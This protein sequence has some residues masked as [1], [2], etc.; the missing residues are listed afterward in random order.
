LSATFHNRILV[1]GAGSVAQCAIPLLLEHLVEAKQM[2]I[3]D[4]R[5][6]RSRVQSAIDQG[7]MYVQEEL[8]PSNLNEFLSRFLSEGDFLL[9][10][11]WNID[12]NAIIEWAHD[13][14]VIYV[15]TSLEEWE[16][17][18]GGPE[19]SVQSRTLYVRHMRIREMKAKWTQTGPTA[20]VEHGANPGFVSHLV[21]RGLVDIATREIKDGLAADGV[22]KALNEGNFPVLA[23]TLG[24]KVIH[25]AERDT[26]VA[27]KPKLLG[28]FVNTWS[29]EGFYEE[30]IA[31]A[32]LGWG[33]H[34]KTL[35]PN[36][37]KLPL[38]NLGQLHGFDHGCQTRKP[39]D[40]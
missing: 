25:I 13:H 12:A 9:D 24:V 11:A 32:E 29:V 17:Y 4:K 34:E 28:E 7:A 10:L 38:P 16:P 2:T 6:N 39:L 37:Y 21:K 40:Y 20:I 8:T 3:V 23:Q 19:R 31:P 5:D 30:G 36:A 22:E 26:Q 1:L 27:D 15:N 33:T 35:P 14:G 18:S